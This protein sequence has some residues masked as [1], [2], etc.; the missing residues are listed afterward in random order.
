MCDLHISCASLKH[1]ERF[2]FLIFS[3]MAFIAS[4]CA[5]T[6]PK[7]GNWLAQLPEDPDYLFAVGGP[8][9][10]RLIAANEAR[11][12]MAKTVSSTIDLKLKI[13]LTETNR[14]VDE[15]IAEQIR[16]ESRHKLDYL[17]I[18]E[19]KQVRKKYYALARMPVRPIETVLNRLRFIERAPKLTEISRSLIIPGWGQ[20]QK[21]QKLKGGVIFATQSLAIA[22]YFVLRMLKRETYQHVLN[23]RGDRARNF[24]MAKEQAYNKLVAGS[25]IVSVGIYLYNFI[26][27]STAKTKIPITETSRSF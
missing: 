17:Q 14:M 3:L 19:V 9:I 23:A 13:I 5:L 18:V 12:E 25:L 6:N 1:T 7:Y 27:V 10:E 26:D 21:G 16:I 20:S 8:Q 22:S 24:W 2:L 4:G 11:A 15:S